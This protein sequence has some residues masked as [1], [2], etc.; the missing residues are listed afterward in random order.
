MFNWLEQSQ[1]EP[2]QRMLVKEKGVKSCGL[3]FDD[4]EKPSNV[5]KNP[6]QNI[7]MIKIQYLKYS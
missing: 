7:L 2:R 5:S 4:D 3:F 1:Y 6:T